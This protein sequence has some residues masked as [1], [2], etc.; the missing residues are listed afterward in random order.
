MDPIISVW[1]L[2]FLRDKAVIKKDKGGYWMGRPP[3][4][5]GWVDSIDLHRFIQ[6][7]II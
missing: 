5:V 6:R 4:F 1:Y 3:F 2:R 7:W